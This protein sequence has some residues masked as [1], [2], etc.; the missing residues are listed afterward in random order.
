MTSGGVLFSPTWSSIGF[1]FSHH[2]CDPRTMAPRSNST[3]KLSP[4]SASDSYVALEAASPPLFSRSDRLPPVPAM[5]VRQS[6]TRE[7]SVVR[8]VRSQKL[9]LLLKPPPPSLSQ[10][11]AILTSA[12]APRGPLYAESTAKSALVITPRVP[13]HLIPFPSFLFRPTLA[14]GVLTC[15][16][17]MMTNCINPM[18]A[19]VRAFSTTESSSRG[20]V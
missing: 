8:S 11:L 13:R 20:G 2:A 5:M 1:L 9:Y 3:M 14:P 15:S 18:T 7:M 10:T 19:T 16:M 4:P 17:T 6:V 12:L